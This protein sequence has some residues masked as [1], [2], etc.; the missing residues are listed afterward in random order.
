MRVYQADGYTSELRTLLEQLMEARGVE[1]PEEL[2]PRTFQ[3]IDT[4]AGD[5]LRVVS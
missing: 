2:N 4:L 3:A 5:L 1:V